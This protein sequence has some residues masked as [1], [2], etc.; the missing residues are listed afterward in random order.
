MIYSLLYCPLAV[1]YI[2][3]YVHTYIHTYVH[4]YIH[5]YVYTVHWP[6]QSHVLSSHLFLSSYIFVLLIHITPS[7]KLSIF[8]GNLIKILFRD[9]GDNA[10]VLGVADGFG[11]AEDPEGLEKNELLRLVEQSL[12]ITAFNRSKLTPAGVLLD[13]STEE[14]LVR[15]NTM[16]FRVKTDAFIPAGGRPNTINAENCMQFV[17]AATG[18]CCNEFSV[19]GLFL[20]VRCCQ[21]CVS[22]HHQHC[23]HNTAH[24]S[25]FD[26]LS[27]SRSLSDVFSLTYVHSLSL[28]F[29]SSAH[30][31]R[32]L[33]HAQV[34]QV[35]L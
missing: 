15:R 26:F 3:T 21:C 1:T 2:H 25:L 4:T 6:L 10:R 11:V 24:K 22:T 13:I 16:H 34:S 33:I 31:T 30:L 18:E 9:Y 12:P 23:V 8:L 28:F 27:I 29:D 35:V 20:F 14:G 5:T 32:S 19:I 17:D 7:P